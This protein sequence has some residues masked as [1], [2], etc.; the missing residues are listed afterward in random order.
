MILSQKRYIDTLAAY[1]PR[2]ATG[3]VPH[4][5]PA[6]LFAVHPTGFTVRCAIPGPE[7]R[8]CQSHIMAN[9]PELTTSAV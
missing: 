3:S 4:H 5:K 2:L 8:A 9:A 1:P 6:L 7:Q